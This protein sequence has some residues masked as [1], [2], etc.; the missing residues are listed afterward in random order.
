RRR[1]SSARRGCSACSLAS[2]ASSDRGR[3]LYSTNAAQYSRKARERGGR[4]MLSHM[5]EWYDLS[6][7]ERKIRDLALE[8]ARAQIAPNAEPD[9]SIL[10]TRREGLPGPIPVMGQRYSL[11]E[12]D[13]A[14]VRSWTYD[15]MG[16]RGA[17][18]G[19]VTFEN[20]RVPK[21][22]A[23]GAERDPMVRSVASKG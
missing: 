14:G 20:V 2:T 22:N 19:G 9:V 5:L 17:S 3:P 10:Q 1:S 6:D 11:I 8:V 23:V 12:G 16:L 4:P 18:N 7:E 13:Y 21:E 15:P